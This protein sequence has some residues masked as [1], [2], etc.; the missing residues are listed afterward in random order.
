MIFEGEISRDEYG[1]KITELK[2]NR[3]RRVGLLETR[4]SSHGS[5]TWLDYTIILGG[6]RGSEVSHTPD[7]WPKWPK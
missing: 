6:T 4:R 3:W 2:N 5:I 1:R 7:T